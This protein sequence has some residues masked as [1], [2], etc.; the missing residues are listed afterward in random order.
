GHR[1]IIESLSRALV[2]SPPLDASKGGYIAAGY[3]A[4]LDRL[5]YAA[6]NGR[7]AIAALEARYRDATGIG[8]LKIRHNAVLGYH[9]EV[10]AR[11]AD[12]LMR[13]DSG[14]TH[15]QTLAGVVRFNSPELHE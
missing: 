12:T 13:P 14:F 1:A 7:R 2:E 4:E 10:S 8:S 6:S 11:Q 15:R 5:L 3:D 9:V